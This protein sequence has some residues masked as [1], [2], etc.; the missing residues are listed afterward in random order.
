MRLSA[1]V[2]WLV[3]LAACAACQPRI[4]LAR[5]AAGIRWDMLSGRIV[6]ARW[7][8]PDSTD[9]RGLM[10]LVDVPARQLTVVRDAP[11]T[12]QPPSFDP[13]GWV[14]EVAFKPGFSIVAF[15]VL[16]DAGLW[17]LR[18]LALDSRIEQVLYPDSKANH[19]FPAW[20]PDGQL[21]YYVN[22]ADGVHLFVD[23]RFVMNGIDPSRA[24]WTTT[25]TF[26]V[27][28]PDATS[29]GALYLAN[30]QTQSLSPVVTGTDIFEDPA[31]DPGQQ[32]L[33]YVRRGPDADAQ[34]IWFAHIDGTGQTRATHGYADS[35]PAWSADGSAI[36]FARFHAGL[37]MYDLA[38]GS[39][40]Q[41]TQ[42]YADA[43]TW[44]Q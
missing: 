37:F 29:A 21:A 33:A 39:I 28:L 9:P 42:G 3:G 24:A 5:E 44:S 41:V 15:S 32:K 30:P 10:F 13:T 36:L 27:C 26:I 38:T 2:G 23:G 6:Y 43:M 20:S 25:G 18:S 40:T 14:R 11:T 1:F 8:Q 16:S 4:D 31:V 22:G 12:G 19:N 35:S 17:E 7:D 34:E